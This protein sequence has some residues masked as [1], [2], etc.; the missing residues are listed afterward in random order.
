MVSGAESARIL[1]VSDI[2]VSFGGITALDGVSLGVSSGEVLG[3][4]GPNGAGKTTR[5]WRT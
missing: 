3:I 5:R 4:I 2:T 1:S